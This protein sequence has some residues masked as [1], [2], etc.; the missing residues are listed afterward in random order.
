MYLDKIEIHGFKSFGNAVKLSIPKGITGVIGPNGSGKSNVADA[1][2]WVLGEQS[3]KSLR[4]SKMEDIIFAGTEKRKSLGYAEVSMSIKNLDKEMPI[5]YT[6]VVIKRRVYRSGESEYFINGSSCRL[7]DVQELFMDTGVGKEGYSIIGQGQIDRVLSSK[8]EERRT[9]FEEAAGIYKYKIRRLEAEKKLE[10]QRENLMRLEDI[11]LEIEARLKPLEL[12]AQKT[13]QFLKLKEKLRQIDINLFIHEFDR[14]EQELSQLN[15]HIEALDLEIRE[16]V[17]SKEGLASKSTHNKK[18]KNELFNEIENLVHEASELE[19]EQERKHSQIEITLEKIANI[20]KLLKQIEQDKKDRQTDNQNRLERVHLL[21]SKKT[22]LEMEKVSQLEKMTQEQQEYEEISNALVGLESSIDDSKQNFYNRVRTI[23]LLKAEIQ[24]NENLENQIAYRSTQI[25]EQMAVLNS[26]IQHEEVNI[27]VFNQD[28]ARLKA[29][30]EKYAVSLNQIEQNKEKLDQA[31]KDKEKEFSNCQQNLIQAERQ[32]KWLQ[33]IKDEH[34]GYYGSVKQV[35]GIVDK[36][37]DKW[38]GVVGVVG[39]LLEV[40]KAYETAIVTA[41]GSS[42]QYIVTLAEDDAKDMIAVMKQKGISRVTFLPKDTVIKASPIKDDSIYQEEGVLGNASELVIYDK[43]YTSIVSS[44]LGRIIIVKDIKS[45][46]RIAKKYQYKYKLVTL[47]GE[48]FHSGGSLS[49]GSTKNQTNN[50]FSRNREIKELQEKLIRY[51]GQLN[52][53]GEALSLLSK[54]LEECI[55]EKNSIHNT[56]VGLRDEEKRI[57]LE[58][59]KKLHEIKLAKAS[60]LQLFTEKNSIEDTLEEIEQVKEKLALEIEEEKQSIK[61]DEGFLQGLEAKLTQIKADKDDIAQNLTQRKIDFSK[62]EQ[63]ILHINEQIQELQ[64]IL[65]NQ[66]EDYIKMEDRVNGYLKERQVLSETIAGVQ[67]EMLLL[68]DKIADCSTRR[69]AYHAQ[70][71]AFEEEEVVIDKKTTDV[72][73]QLEQLKEERYRLESKK[74]NWDMQRQNLGNMMWEQYELTY[75]HALSYKQDLGSISDLRK[76]SSAIKAEIKSIGSVNVNAVEEYTET[77]IRY[78]FL[79]TQKADIQQ[80]E[81]TLLEMIEN[82]TLQM[83][84]IFSEQFKMIAANF[85]LV[86]KELFGGG[87]AY[88]ELSDEQNILESG[89]EI[90]AKPPGKKLQN[91]SLLSGGERTLT[92]ISLLFGILKLKPS[93]FCVLDEIESALDDANVLR[94]AEYLHKLSDETQFIVITHRKGTMER[95]HTL[96]GVTMQERGVSTLL[97]IKLGDANHYL[98]QKKTS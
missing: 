19:K 69:E 67:E 4:G 86:F 82:L 66:E 5:D 54:D 77:K 49:G 73:E 16:K 53:L 22:A 33:H 98:D 79:S 32:L 87:E 14:L 72:L 17:F 97:S 28:K 95:A 81:M 6:E 85:T 34:E 47:E 84:A 57:E 12:E 78:E 88:L 3:A 46:S 29:D 20:E 83:K 7:K 70:K 51:N 25:I 92:A 94:F 40:S 75:N 90:I 30:G 61:G 68:K 38:Q 89:I 26:E 37:R 23:D 15:S 48:I 63:N 2:R 24:K 62:V 65:E 1:I 44:L 9:L 71:L 8:P 42:I 64:A 56:L 58:L 55:E 21:K 27:Q 41:L 10:K 36:D 60:Q 31:K 93:P 52:L 50:I 96:Y 80:A 11:I 13:K 39:E 76:E 45:A 43:T 35:L 18:L 91:M 74:Q 59:D